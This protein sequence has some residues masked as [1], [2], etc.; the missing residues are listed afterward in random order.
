MRD[1]YLRGYLHAKVIKNFVLY[2][3]NLSLASYYYSM[4]LSSIIGVTW[5][6]FFF[7]YKKSSSFLGRLIGSLSKTYNFKII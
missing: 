4:I 6:L 1:S 3:K 2:N 5:Y 7:D